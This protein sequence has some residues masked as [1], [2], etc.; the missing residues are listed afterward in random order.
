MQM[1]Q[2]SRNSMYLPVWVVST[3][4]LEDTYLDGKHAGHH[5]MFLLF[6]NLFEELLPGWKWCQTFIEKCLHILKSYSCL[7]CFHG[8]QTYSLLPKT[9]FLYLK[10]ALE[11]L[12][13]NLFIFL[14]WHIAWFLGLQVHKTLDM[15]AVTFPFIICLF[16]ILLAR[17]TKLRISVIIKGH[18]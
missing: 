1:V 10:K 8:G 7:L 14:Q 6:L 18:Y 15:K 16:V 13:V 2:M 5:E 11:H 17:K 3:G 9:S 12:L 4:R